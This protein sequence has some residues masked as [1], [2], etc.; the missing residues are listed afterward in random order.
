MHGAAKQN[1]SK[2]CS[3]WVWRVE[4]LPSAICLL[5]EIKC[6]D[7]CHVC[8]QHPGAG[9]SQVPVPHPAVLQQVLGLARQEETRAPRREQLGLTHVQMGPSHGV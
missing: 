3:V 8:R 7:P 4:R 5:K 1:G 6:N 2:S 9:S